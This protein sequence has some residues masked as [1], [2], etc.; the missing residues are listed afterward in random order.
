MTLGIAFFFFV[1]HRVSLALARRRDGLTRRCVAGL[2]PAAAHCA[3]LRSYRRGRKSC[4]IR[5]EKRSQPNC[6][7]ERF[8]LLSVGHGVAFALLRLM[9]RIYH[10][11]AF[12]IESR[13]L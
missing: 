9:K 8:F 10:G 7:T 3:E 6:M 2:S 12:F 5:Q 4:A 1:E 11:S 13:G